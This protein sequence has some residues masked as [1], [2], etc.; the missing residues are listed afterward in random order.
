MANTACATA[1]PPHAA[2][3]RKRQAFGGSRHI[4]TIHP[5]RSVV[6]ATKKKKKKKKK[7]KQ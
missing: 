2:Q 5:R 6:N 1:D 3:T 7:K 4:V